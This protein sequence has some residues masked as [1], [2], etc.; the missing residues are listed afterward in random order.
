MTDVGHLSH[1][2]GISVTRWTDGLHLSQKQYA[3]GV[4][5]CTRMTKCNPIK[6]SISDSELLENPTIYCRLNSALQYLT[7]THL[8]ISYAVHH[9]CTPIIPSQPR[10]RYSEDTLYL[11]TYI[12]PSKS[13][14]VAYS[15]ADWTGSRDALWSTTGF[16]V[17]LGDNLIMWPSKCQLTVSRSSTEA[18]KRAV[19]HVVAQSCWIRQILQELHQPIHVRLL[20]IVTMFLQ[21]TSPPIPFSIAT[22]NKSK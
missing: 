22:A 9:A 5:Q 1:F 8:E 21:F 2:P 15:H 17:L 16:C 14:L 19:A 4:I 7:L 6:H 10:L 11:G 13:S 18:E 20:S 3:L 12:S